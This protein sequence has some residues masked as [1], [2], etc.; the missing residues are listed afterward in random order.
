MY[1]YEGNS[2]DLKFVEKGDGGLEELVDELNGGKV[3][4]AFIKVIDPNTKLPKNVLVNWMGEGVPSSRKGVCARHVNDVARFFRGAHVTINAR[5]EDDLDSD[6]VYDK[7]AKASGANFS[8]H[9]EKAQVIP[10]QGQVG[11][12]YQ[13]AKPQ[14][15]INV[16]SRDDFWSKQEQ[17]EEKRIAEEKRLAAQIRRQEELDRRQRELDEGLRRDEMA[18]ARAKSIDEQRKRET[19]AERE[20]RQQKEALLQARLKK[21]EQEVDSQMERERQQNLRQRAQDRSVSSGV[22]DKL[23]GFEKKVEEQTKVPPRPVPKRPIKKPPV[24]PEPEPEPEPEP[25]YQYEPEPDPEPEYQYEP[26]LL[27]TSPSPLDRTRSR[28]PSSA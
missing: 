5:S 16:T 10:E 13:R 23:A 7:V 9:K 25:Q 12:V 14:Q 19:D 17:E 11:S 2:N 26:C 6:T 28:M 24:K 27:Y 1:G 18:K 8:F 20:E 4:Y 3:M 15:E 21:E 22:R